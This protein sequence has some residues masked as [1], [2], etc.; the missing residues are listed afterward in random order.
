MSTAQA[1]QTAT[2]QL[3]T[4][5]LKISQLEAGATTAQ[6]TIDGHAATIA[7]QETQIDGHAS[8]LEAK[9]TAHAEATAGLNTKIE[10]LTGANET[11]ASENK[12]LNRKIANP[13]YK[14]ASAEGEDPDKAGGGGGDANVSQTPL[15]DAYNALETPSAKSAHWDKNFAAMQDEQRAL[16][17]T[18]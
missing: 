10:E 13:A 4:A 9:D 1:L 3:E 12:E 17:A 15:W 14:I 18:K 16:A 2:A 7:D 6:E 8:A 5:N 11:L